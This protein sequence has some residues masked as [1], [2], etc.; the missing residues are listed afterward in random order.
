MNDTKIFNSNNNF[1]V[2]EYLKANKLIHSNYNCL[3]CNKL[4][5]WKVR[6]GT[7]DGFGFRCTTC[8]NKPWFSIRS[9]RFFSDIRLPLFI[10]MKLIFYWAI[11]VKITDIANILDVSAKT[12]V[13]Y[14]K[15]IRE[16]CI[17]ALN[18]ENLKIGGPGIVVEIDESLFAKVINFS[19]TGL[20][21]LK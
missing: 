9:N 13:K 11:Q 4:T 10:L 18:R 7:K 14:F 5:K 3:T 1:E 19:A 20:N 21:A 16:I 12:I 8:K 2:I 6:K 17:K 15:I